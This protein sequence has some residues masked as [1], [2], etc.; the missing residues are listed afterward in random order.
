MSNSNT[1]KNALT[2]GV[3]STDVVLPEENKQEFDD[4]LQAY[5]DEYCPDGISEEAAIFDLVSLYWKKRR[6]EAGLQQAYQKQLDLDAKI[7]AFDLGPAVKSQSEAVQS[8]CKIVQT[9][10]EQIYGRVEAKADTQTVNQAVDFDKLTVLA[11]ELNLV[12]SGFIVPSLQAAEK[13][14]LDQIERACLLHIME[15]E[16]K[17]QAEIDR[18]IEKVLKRLVAVKEYKRF[19]VAK[20]VN[21]NQIEAIKLR[22][23]PPHESRGS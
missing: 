23:E 19:Y 10:L 20:S 4:L 11:K 5:R 2:H 15:K 21:A 14:K 9:H 22:A 7:A 3:Y 12:G 16:L 18:R 6:L 17:I 1:S 13:L 8:V